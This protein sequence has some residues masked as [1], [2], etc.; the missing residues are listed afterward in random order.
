M[1]FVGDDKVV[2]VLDGY[3]PTKIST[4]DV[5]RAVAKYISDGG[6]VEDIEMFSYVATGHSFAVLRTPTFTWTLDL[7]NLRWHE[8]QSYLLPYWRAYDSV[9]AFGKW[10]AGDSQG[11]NI[12]QITD[13]VQ[14]ELNQ[15]IPFDIYSGPVTAFPNRLR[16]SQTTIDIARGVGS[17]TGINPIQTDPTCL[18]SWSDDGGMNWSEP[19]IRKLGRQV[20]SH[21]P[22]RVNRVGHTK[23]QGRRYRIVV[24]DPVQVE[25][26]GGK[27]DA[28]VRNYNG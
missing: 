13:T 17:I 19:V 3:N 8:R 6:S 22:V 23:D 18:I 9:N 20:E 10:L 12:L 25:L 26:T 16:V 4:A 24:Y 21:Y 2:Y 11:N 5:D 1:I 28:E 15:P 7:D 14:T 27:M